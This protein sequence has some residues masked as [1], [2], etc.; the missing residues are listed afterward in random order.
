MWWKRRAK[1]P[2]RDARDPATAAAAAEAAL[3]AAAARLAAQMATVPEHVRNLAITQVSTDAAE[4]AHLVNVIAL[5]WL[6]D[7]VIT[8]AEVDAMMASMLDQPQLFTALL[9]TIRRLGYCQALTD[10]LEERVI[11]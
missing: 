2:A 6:R 1:R 11:I 7:G 5:A 8:E 4:Y 3:V 9:V 10:L